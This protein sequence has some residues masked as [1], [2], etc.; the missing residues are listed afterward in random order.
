MFKTNLKI[1]WRNLLKDKQ[2]TLLN[3]LG[4][5]A[6]LA[7]TLLI[8]LWVHDEMSYD[9]FFAND[10]RLYQVMEHRKSGGDIQLSDESSGIVTDIIKAGYPEA[11]YAA[12]L[13]PPEWFQQFTLSVGDKNIKA[14]GQYAG[15]DYFNIFSFKILEGDKSK[16][17]ENRNYIVISDELAMKLFGTTTNILGKSI[18]FQHDTTFFVSGVFEKV[19]TH[20]SQQFDFVLSF[21]YYAAVQSWVKIWGNTGPHNFV[22]LRKGVDVNTFNKHISRLAVTNFQDTGRIPFAAKFSDNYLLNSFDHGSQV[23]GKIGYVRLFSLIAI[24]ILCIACINFMN[25][26]TAKASRR[27]KEVGIKKVAGAGR[28]QLIFQF[29]SESVLLTIVAMVFALVIAWLLLPAF[30][31]L[32]GKQISLSF[33]PRIIT[34]F[35]CIA[36]ITGLLAGSYP[37]LYLSKFKP[38]AILKGK[39]NTSFAEVVSRK[40]MVI[41]QFTLSAIMIVAVIIIY[42]Q[43]QFIQSTNPGYNKDNIVRF[44]SEGSI[45]GNEDNFVAELKKLPG[46]INASFTFNNMVGRNYGNYALSWEGKDPN[47]G[48]YFEGFGAGYNFIE[49]MGMHMASGRSFSENFGDEFS[50]I[51]LNES[52]I[53]IMHLKDPVGKN[54]MFN[55]QPRQIIGVVKDF[56]FESLHEPVKPAYFTLQQ[57]PGKNPWFKI[58]IRIKAGNQQQTIA[59]IQHLYEDYNPGFPFTFNFLDEAY[60]KQYDTETR[61]SEL[62][63]YFAGLAIIISCLGLFGLAAFTA[64]KRQKEIGIRK[65]IGA[66]V[67]NI[68]AMLS[69]DFLI[70]VS[71]SLLIALP[72]SWLLMNRWLQSFAYRI[73]ITPFV[74]VITAVSVVLVTLITI[75]YQSVKAA[76]ANPIKSLRTE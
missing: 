8:Y 68:T 56:H 28:A 19:P 74:F 62:S 31:Q 75:S 65:V 69:K 76:L 25:L 5:S 9:K 34:G 6:G 37:A 54:I 60:Q 45:Q 27:L 22:L 14:K 2:F 29:L 42:Q 11:A 52:A 44:D 50:K 26:S 70:L 1:A 7:C 32:T 24:F 53:R 17:L 21:E 59:A 46:V 49:T 38:L 16:V 36:L 55:D 57:N 3:V 39:L 33:D 13:A 41:F 63:K 61:V 4:L 48:I 10:D 15:K 64:Q 35:I 43:I 71:I 47:A 18:E 73:N 67:S 23:G 66:S 30:N 58:M 40:G 20:S 72:V 12:A 51:I